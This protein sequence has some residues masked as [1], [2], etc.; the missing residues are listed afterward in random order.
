MVDL[1][2][3][4]DGSYRVSESTSETDIDQDNQNIES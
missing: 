1:G 4:L 3:W 2:R